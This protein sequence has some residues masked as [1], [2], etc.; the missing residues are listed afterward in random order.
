MYGLSPDY[1]GI[2]AISLSILKSLNKDKFHVDF[3]FS[4]GVSYKYEKQITDAQGGIFYITPWGRNP[5]RFRWELEDFYA[6]RSGYDYVWI[7]TSAASNI[8]ILTTTR[9]C[10][11]ARIIVHSHGVFFECRNFLKRYVLH[12]LH[13]LNQTKLTQLTD[14]AFSCSAMAADWLFGVEYTKTHAVKIVK[15][16]V[17]VNAFRFDSKI[18]EH[19]RKLLN[20]DKAIVLMHVGRFCLEKNQR[21]LIEVFCEL[22]KKNSN[23]RL[24]FVGDGDTRKEMMQKASE[25][26]LDGYIQ[27]LGHRDDVCQLLQAAD[28]FLLPSLCEGLPVTIIEAQAAGLPCLI[29]DTITNEVAVTNLVRYLPL[30]AGY[31]YW[32]NQIL[33][34]VPNQERR[35]FAIK[36]ESSGFGIRRM[37]D[38][39]E[40]LLEL[41]VS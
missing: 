25:G 1:G 17:A 24:V 35:G 30:E 15:N 13:N 27:F 3:L 29:T 41:H 36:V 20:I 32:A 40:N 16:A 19:Y 21:F 23:Y 12:F 10:T 31:A 6:T 26:K 38:D 9:C 28:L 2:E 34:T 7:H 18:R 11:R 39:I 22:L 33:E 8:M 4:A 14:H 5:I 37:V